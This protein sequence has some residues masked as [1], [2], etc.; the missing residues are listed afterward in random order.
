[1]LCA[2]VKAVRSSVSL[3]KQLWTSHVHSG[4]VHHLPAGPN[5][6]AAPPVLTDSSEPANTE[7]KRDSISTWTPA[8]GPPPLPTHCCMSGC[9]NCVWI[10][11]A[12]QLLE[13]YN[14]GSERALVA[15]E[16]N[17]LDENLKTYLKMEIRLLKKM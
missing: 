4:I 11:H 8:Q 10:E 16:E 5:S 9:H 1:M 3:R 2:G 13:Y 17:V 6:P 7:Q 12:E 14:D 15:I